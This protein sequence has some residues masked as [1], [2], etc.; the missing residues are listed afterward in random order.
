M[1]PDQ[2][3]GKPKGPDTSDVVDN[4]TKVAD[5]KVMTLLLGRSAKAAGDYLGEKAEDYFKKRRESSRNKNI[6]DHIAKVADVTGPLPNVEEFQIVRIEQWIKIAADIPVE[7]IERSAV[8]EA[9]LDNIVSKAEDTSEFQEAAEKLTNSTARL[10]LNA[11]AERII[12]PKET[13]ERGFEELKSLGL[14]GTPSKRQLLNDLGAW[15]LGTIGGLIVLFGVIIRYAPTLLP[16]Y[17]PSFLATEFVAEAVAISA[18]SLVL[19]ILGLSTSYRLTHLGKSLQ[20]SA[21]R[22]YRKD[23]SAQKKSGLPLVPRRTWIMWGGLATLLVCALPFVLQA[24]IPRQLRIDTQPPTVIISSAPPTP[25]SPSPPT[26]PSASSPATPQGQGVTLSAD[27]VRTLVEVWQSVADQMSDILALT[28]DGSALLSNWPQRIKDGQSQALVT[29]LN[30]NRSSM[31]QR[32]TS[33]QSLYDA[34]QTYPNVSAELQNV[35]A[36]GYNRFSGAVDGFLR[37]MQTLRTPPPDNAESLVRPYA[38]EVIGALDAMAKWANGTRDF[39]R[40]QSVELSQIDL[41]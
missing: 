8:I 24:Y 31:Q 23:S 13:N 11:P 26:P 33:L 20:H 38:T 28:N 25:N 10:L 6:E 27:Q 29:E 35:A 34:Y 16:R 12:S 37:E 4:V 32:I 5:S 2:G 1:S 22:F 21:N 41:R 17:F 7:D 14:A 18:L 30:N 40:R 19:G 15:L 9:V 39:A 3:D 36:K